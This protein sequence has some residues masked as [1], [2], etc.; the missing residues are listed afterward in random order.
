MKKFKAP[1]I[2]MNYRNHIS[3]SFLFLKIPL[4]NDFRSGEEFYTTKQY[5]KLYNSAHV[6]PLIVS[7][8]LNNGEGV[9][10]GLGRLLSSGAN[11][12]M[13]NKDL[14]QIGVRYTGSVIQAGKNINEAVNPARKANAEIDTLKIIKNL[15]KKKD[16]LR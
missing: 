5:I 1:S 15:L 7:K 8:Q 13:T 10:A 11:F 6:N 3:K 9:F 4:V 2:L 12:V 14:I 16:S